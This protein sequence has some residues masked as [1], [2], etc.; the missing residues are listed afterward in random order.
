MGKSIA[1][2][3]KRHFP[4]SQFMKK[5]LNNRNENGLVTTA[6]SCSSKF[7]MFDIEQKNQSVSG[8][9]IIDIN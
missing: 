1:G 6:S 5:Y 4:D 7:E 2:K 9:R 3:R 8:N